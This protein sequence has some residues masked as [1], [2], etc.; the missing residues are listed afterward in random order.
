MSQ[1]S[2]CLSRH[3]SKRQYHWNLNS[4]L[5]SPLTAGNIACS[6]GACLGQVWLHIQNKFLLAIFWGLLMIM[7]PHRRDYLAE[8]ECH[9]RRIKRT[10]MYWIIVSKQWRW[11]GEAT[12]PCIE[13]KPWGYDPPEESDGLC[14]CKH[15]RHGLCLGRETSPVKKRIWISMCQAQWKNG[16]GLACAKPSEKNGS[17]LAWAKPSEK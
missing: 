1:A 2:T 9:S 13:D 10:T 12:T 8:G 5:A 14:D 6:L 4:I 16:S 3:L 7:F 15:H 17:G 11:Q